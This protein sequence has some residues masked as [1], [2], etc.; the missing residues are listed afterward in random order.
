MN[1]DNVTIRRKT[2]RLRRILYNGYFTSFPLPHDTLLEGQV[3]LWRG[4][5]DRHL[6]DLIEH[7]LIEKNFN[8]YYEAIR[9]FHEQENG[10]GQ[11]HVLACIE[12]QSVVKAFNGIENLC[13]NLREK[14]VK[15]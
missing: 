11:E 7:H 4:V 3:K 2:A 5:L 1:W 12:I 10:K 9:F 14:G 6:K 15:L 8:H 13:R